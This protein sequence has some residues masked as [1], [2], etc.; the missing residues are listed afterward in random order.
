MD[1]RTLLLAGL[2]A[3]LLAGCQT[4]RRSVAFAARDTMTIARPV[5][6]RP[7]PVTRAPLA[8]L[9][10]LGP[11]RATPAP[12]SAV[13][14]GPRCGP[15][16]RVAA[17][18]LTGRILP[19]SKVEDIVLDDHEVI[20]TFDDGPARK[21]TPAI[22]DTLDRYGVK[23]TF[24]MVGQMADAS[25]DLVREVAARGH[26]IGSHTAAHTDLSQLD[27]SDAFA[28]I[29]RGERAVNAALSGTGLGPA[30]FFRFP[31]LADTKAL[32]GDLAKRGTIVLDVDIDSRDY[33][34]VTP[35]TVATDTMAKLRERKSGIILFHDIH[36][37]TVAMLPDFLETLTREG[38]RVVELVPDTDAACVP[39]P[40][41]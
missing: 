10:P 39:S 22:L 17:T 21:R 30:Q 3:G 16:T 8:P 35:E 25:P 38:Y 20:L 31:Y 19:V 28:E 11:S 26:S 32:R 13:P 9:A 34:Q 7:A 14:P 18:A 41:F 5:A 4:E 27:E 6:V 1:L 23:A 15:D 2:A 36:A 24:L 40:A 37:R 12:E 29:A 33:H